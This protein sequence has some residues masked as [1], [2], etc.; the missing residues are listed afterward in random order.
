M[1]FLNIFNFSKFIGRTVICGLV[2]G[3]KEIRGKLL[4]NPWSINHQTVE[5]IPGNNIFWIGIWILFTTCQ[6]R[7]ILIAFN[8]ELELSMVWSTLMGMLGAMFTLFPL[9]NSQRCKLHQF[10]Y[11]KSDLFRGN[12]PVWLRFVKSAIQKLFSPCFSVFGL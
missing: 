11:N 1:N 6:L 5:W 3:L 12:F 10:G 2:L 4:I 7:G 9:T 8:I